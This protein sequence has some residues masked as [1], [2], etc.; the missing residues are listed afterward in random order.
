M[1]WCESLPCDSAIRCILNFPLFSTI[2]FYFFASVLFLSS[3]LFAISS[4]SPS[5]FKSIRFSHS[6]SGASIEKNESMIAVFGTLRQLWQ[7]QKTKKS[8]RMRRCSFLFRFYRYTVVKICFFF[9]FFISFIEQNSVH[10]HPF[11]NFNRFRSVWL[12]RH[13][14][15]VHTIGR[16][17]TVRWDEARQNERNES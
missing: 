2:W 10:S 1:C 16:R 6:L 4:H 9:F 15:N 7:M 12:T 5:I 8:G 3:L 11:V 13:K 17:T 14:L